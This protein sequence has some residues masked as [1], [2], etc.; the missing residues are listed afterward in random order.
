M[1]AE[2]IDAA[3]AA[4]FQRPIAQRPTPHASIRTTPLNEYA[5]GVLCRWVFA[6][7]ILDNERDP[8]IFYRLSARTQTG[9]ITVR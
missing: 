4:T 8:E 7:P 5:V 1:V 2:N 6:A 9:E 3:I